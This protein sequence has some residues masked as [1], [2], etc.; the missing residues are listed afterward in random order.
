[1]VQNMTYD[2][3]ILRII[4]L[5]RD[6]KIKEFRNMIDELQPYD[7]A[8]LFKEMPEKHRARYL[9]YMTVDDITD[10]IGELEREFQLAVL[11]KVGKTKATLAMNKMDNDDLAALLEE[12]DEELKEQLLSSMEAEESKAVQLLMNYPQESA[13]RMMTNRFVWIPQHYTVK[14]AVVKLK[15]FAEIAESINYLYVINDSKQLVG[16]LSYRDLI[17]GEPEDKVQD[18][19]FTRVISAGVLQDQE[20]VARLIQRYDFLAIPIVEENHV[21]VGI[22]TV[23]DIIDVVIKEADEDYEKFAASGKAIT[24]D[25]KAYVAAYRRLPWLI[26]LLFIGLISGSILNYFEDTLQ[27]VVALAFFMPMI[28]GTTGNTGTQSL[29]VVIRGLAKE[30]M[31][32]KTIFKL[33]FRELRTSIYIGIVCAIAITIVA[34]VWQKD[35][36][37]GFVVGSSLLATLIIGTMAGTIVPIIL[38]KLNIDPAIASGPLITTLNDILSLLIYFGIATAFLHAL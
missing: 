20:E 15:S 34:T 12:M 7:M 23:D 1:M 17:L 6:G 26:L 10:M 3:L 29:A 8:F 22:V 28:A 9:S 2:E 24:F 36:T 37:L 25:T 33:I 11:H 5:L 35:L 38:H 21:L 18:L 14:D 13:G 19:M 30:E 32:K 31:N 27:K 16:V 4:I